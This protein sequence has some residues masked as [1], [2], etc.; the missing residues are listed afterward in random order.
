MLFQILKDSVILFLLI[1]ALITL[2]EKL[3]RYIA[4]ITDFH[5]ESLPKF[6][7]V[8]ASETPVD[9]LECLLRKELSS[10]C[11]AVYVITNE[12]NEEAK[13]IIDNLACDYVTLF[14]IRKEDLQAIITVQELPD[15]SL[16]VESTAD[17]TQDK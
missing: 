7:V 6:Y 14:P 8:D 15:V 13:T 17:L 3:C 5:D 2:A 10:C 9:K 11:D 12:A 4:R 1:Y 16:K